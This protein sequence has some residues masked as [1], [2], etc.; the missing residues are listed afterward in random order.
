MKARPRKV[1]N[2]VAEEISEFLKEYDLPEVER[3]PVLGRTGPD[4][5]VWPS[6]KVAVDVKSRKANPK[7]YITKYDA[8]SQWGW[9]G[10]GIGE[11]TVGC[12]LENL[13][14]L[15]DIENPT[16]E[17]NPRPASKVV[18]RW[19]FHM[20]EWCTEQES[21][22]DFYNLPALV[23]HYSHQPVAHST[24]VIYKEDRRALNDRRKRINDLRLRAGDE[25]RDDS[26]PD[27]AKSFV[28]HGSPGEL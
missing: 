14:L 18:S 1:E 25:Q 27:W 22:N 5:S 26:S 28:S 13:D 9:L 11:L 7:G 21:K 3:I 4:I 2:R 6:F 10:D 23:L 12:R 8:I 16:P 24:F 20:L 17:L 19:L 15:F